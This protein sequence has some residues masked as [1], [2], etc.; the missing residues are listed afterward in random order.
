MVNSNFSHFR[1]LHV[2]QCFDLLRVQQPDFADKLHPIAGDLLEPD[3]AISP[4]DQTFLQENIDVVV[5]SAASVNF[6]EPLR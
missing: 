6:N 2:L 4:D 5:H 3:L 1:P